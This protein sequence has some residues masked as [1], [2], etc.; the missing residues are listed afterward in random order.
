MGQRFFETLSRVR[1]Y[2]RFSKVELTSLL[3]VTLVIGFIF[4]MR[5]PGE[6]L[7][8]F[9]WLKF[10]FLSVIL[11]ALSMFTRISLQKI[12]ALHRG[13]Y[14]EFKI[15]W[16]GLVGSLIVAFLSL[17]WVPLILVGGLNTIFMVRQRL[18]EFRYGYSYEENSVACIWGLIGNL[19]L[20]TLFG[21]LSLAYPESFF[22]TTGITMNLIMG[23]C[24]LLPLPWLDGLKVFFGS[25]FYYFVALA[26]WLLV[27]LLLISGT[28]IGLIIVV[29]AGVLYIIFNMLWGD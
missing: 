9:N 1:E 16:E 21:I 11:A 27:T 6:E 18:G 26:A 7:R 19:Y 4:S 25:R 14:G 8:F 20:A 5:H 28:K 10:F 24:F 17:G 12:Y 15:W 29:L 23:I 13:Y 3:V 22:F 2:F